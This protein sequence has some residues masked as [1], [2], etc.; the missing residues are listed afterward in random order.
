MKKVLGFSV[1]EY[2]RSYL[3]TLTDTQKNKL[4]LEE[5][6][7]AICYDC[8]ED[9]FKKLNEDNELNDDCVD[10]YGNWWF[11]VDVD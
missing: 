4:Y 3:E 8:V 2:D 7:N 10:I 6:D 9:F 5:R 11:V 1:L